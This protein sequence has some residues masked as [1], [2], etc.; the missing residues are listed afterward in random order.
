MPDLS[1]ICGQVQAD[2]EKT[3]QGVR[4]RVTLY[5]AEARGVLGQIDTADIIRHLEEDGY[6]VREPQESEVHQ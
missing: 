2:P 1:I 6:R 3:A 5:D 4:M